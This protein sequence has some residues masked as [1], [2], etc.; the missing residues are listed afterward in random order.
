[1]P[2]P[3]TCCEESVEGFAT[4]LLVA[5]G[6]NQM[7]ALF[8]YLTILNLG[9]ALMRQGSLAEARRIFEEIL[10]EDEHH[11][12]AHYNLAVCATRQ[13]RPA[14]VIATLG[15]ASARLGESIVWSWLNS[16]EFDS[17]RTN[18]DFVAFERRLGISAQST[19]RTD[20]APR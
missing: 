6:G 20:L 4:P 11:S 2:S 3:V 10:R 15:V 17:I 12:M 9:I 1:M 19:N 8:T 7:M 13:G 18:A 5:T 14:D 16:A